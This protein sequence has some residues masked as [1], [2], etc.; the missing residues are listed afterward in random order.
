M[1]TV[2]A[3]PGWLSGNFWLKCIT[4]SW[5]QQ[6]CASTVHQHSAQ[7]ISTVHSASA[8][9]HWKQLWK[10]Q[11]LH[12]SVLGPV[13]ALTLNAAPISLRLMVYRGAVRP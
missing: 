7:C 12:H 11:Q 1:P 5:R 4:S 10:L 9:L 3:S 13:S 6:P 2:N 8:Q